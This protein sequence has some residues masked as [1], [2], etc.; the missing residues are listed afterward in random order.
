MKN[1]ITL[2]SIAIG[3]LLTFVGASLHLIMEPKGLDFGCMMA[4]AYLVGYGMGRN[5]V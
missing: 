4:G 1:K 2:L 3:G 5:S